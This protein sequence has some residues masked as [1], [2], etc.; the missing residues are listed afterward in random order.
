[1][2][3]RRGFMAVLVGTL[4]SLVFGAAT[5]GAAPSPPPIYEA[6][7]T[8]TPPAID[9]FGD[10]V[11]PAAFDGGLSCSAACSGL[12]GSASFSLSLQGTRTAPT[13]PYRFRRSAGGLSVA[14]SDATSSLASVSARSRDHKDYVLEGTISSGRFV[15]FRLSGWMSTP[16]DAS[17]SGGFVGELDFLPPNPV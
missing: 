16:A 8:Y 11:L 13:D 14:W 3:L 9:P 17:Q 10:A 6:S 12:P 5:A 7:G 1:M 15:G 4:V 2:N